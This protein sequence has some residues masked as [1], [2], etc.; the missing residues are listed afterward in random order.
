MIIYLFLK[1]LR[2]KRKV[3]LLN[4]PSKVPLTWESWEN[5]KVPEVFT[6]LHSGGQYLRYGTGKFF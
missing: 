1:L 2:Y 3:K 6:K 4:L 5:F